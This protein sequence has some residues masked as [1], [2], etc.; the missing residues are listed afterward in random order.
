MRSNEFVSTEEIVGE[1]T[2]LLNDSDFTH[3]VSKSFYE[4]VVHRTIESL[5]LHTF[6]HVATKDIFNWNSCD[7]M[8]LKIPKN[9]FNIKQIYLFNSTCDSQRCNEG[10]E[11]CS[12]SCCND[13]GCWSSYV[14]AHWKR[15]FNRF[16]SSGLKT[17]KISPGIVDPVY[18][19]DFSYVDYPA[20]VTR[21]IG[22]LVYFGVQNGEICFSDS[23]ACF[24]NVR[25]VANGFAV[26][27]C[28]LPIIPREL[29]Q[30]CVDE[31]KMVA[32]KKFMIHFPE[33]KDMY[34]VYYNDLYGDGSVQNPGSRLR[35]ERFISSLNSKQRDDMFEYFG[36]IDIK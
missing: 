17:S 25:I 7:D 31:V 5:A 23:A 28:E 1:A 33:Y 30:V 24:N 22:T 18:Q 4:L 12:G 8:K 21:P 32:C 9:L 16:G 10:E 35:A 36:N 20:N 6:F 3:G 34:K 29:R 14:E 2:E 26:D 11:N 19:R 13:R 15:L 27:N